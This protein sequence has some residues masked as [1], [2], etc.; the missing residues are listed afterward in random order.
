MSEDL[1]YI[2]DR[3]DNLVSYSCR[4]CIEK[5]IEQ[6]GAIHLIIDYQHRKF[7]PCKDHLHYENLREV[8]A[9]LVHWINAID[10]T[11]KKYEDGDP[12][13][14]VDRI[15]DNLVNVVEKQQQ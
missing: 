3:Q 15:T 10:T 14:F 13:I 12:G 2:Y 8:R 4:E 6:D 5:H 7:G 1:I 9:T 11:I